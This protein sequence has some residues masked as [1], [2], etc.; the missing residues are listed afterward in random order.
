MKVDIGPASAWTS[1]VRSHPR[2]EV[3]HIE[4]HSDSITAAHIK[5]RAGNR[6]VIPLYR[7]TNLHAQLGRLPQISIPVSATIYDD[8][9]AARNHIG[10]RRIPVLAHQRAPIHKN[11]HESQQDSIRD[12]RNQN[13]L[14]QR[15]MRNEAHRYVN[16]WPFG[17]WMLAP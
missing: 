10:P 1:P 15:K 13:H 7:L 4:A 11:Q 8:A 16:D 9:G 6:T 3:A 2:S 5:G 17:R 14:Q 12:L